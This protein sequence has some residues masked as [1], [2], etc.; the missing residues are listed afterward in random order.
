MRTM[1]PADP[2]KEPV[3]LAPGEVLVEGE[4]GSLTQR[5]HVG[6]HLLLADEPIGSGGT[7]LGP[8]PYGLLTSALGACTSVTLL[9]YAA[10]KNY[11]LEAVRVRLRHSKVHATDCQDCDTKDEKIDQIEIEIELLGPLS[12]GERAQLLSIAERCPVHRTLHSAVR[13][14]IRLRA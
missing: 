6:R 1:I 7:D 2:L 5:M 4:V 8:D 10:R 11:P 14:P 3:T 13:L 12:A 9:L